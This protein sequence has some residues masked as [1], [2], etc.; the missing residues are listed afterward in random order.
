MLFEGIALTLATGL[1]WCLVGVVYGKATEKPEGFRLFLALG[2]LCFA[3]S[4]WGA[5]P[6][7]AARGTV[8][9]G[10]A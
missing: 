7:A 4:S 9:P 2:A 3:L 6:P 1:L 5:N 8:R 10:A